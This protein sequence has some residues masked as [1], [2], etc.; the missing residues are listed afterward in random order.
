MRRLV[1]ALLLAL[2][3][4]SAHAS[5]RGPWPV[6]QAAPGWHV[7][8]TGPTRVPQVPTAVASNVRLPRAVDGRGTPLALLRV[9]PRR[10]IV[11][12][13]SAYGR[14]PAG[15]FDR[16]VFPPRTPPLRMAQALRRR[17]WVGQPRR[18]M[19]EYLIGARFRGRIV[20]ARVY[21]GTGA[22]TRAGRRA[23]DGELAR[24][25]IRG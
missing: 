23:A 19:S 4:G 24:L 25:R 12:V 14:V 16:R 7:R 13:V 8:V 3:A 6:F 11:I 20:D 1:V 18:S 22:A 10:G 5:A 17:M 15:A 2:A 21:F 9:L